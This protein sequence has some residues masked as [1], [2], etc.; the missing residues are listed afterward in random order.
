[1]TMKLDVMGTAAHKKK[2]APRIERLKEALHAHGLDIDEWDM[3][4]RTLHAGRGKVRTAWIV[5]VLVKPTMVTPIE[6]TED[7]LLGVDLISEPAAPEVMAAMI[8]KQM[9]NEVR[10]VVAQGT[11]NPGRA[12]AKADAIKKAAA[13]KVRKSKKGRKK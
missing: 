6:L 9:V 12:Y 11:L 13:L 4:V 2:V 8:A 1:M 3:S 10:E 7:S 5:Q